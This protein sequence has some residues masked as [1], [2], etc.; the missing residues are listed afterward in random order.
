[1][2]NP[3]STQQGLGHF[4]DTVLDVVDGPAVSLGCWRFPFLRLSELLY[5]PVLPAP[6][7]SCLHILYHKF[8]TKLESHKKRH[9]P[10]DCCSITSLCLNTFEQVFPSYV[11][12]VEHPLFIF[13]CPNSARF[14]F[15]C[16]HNNLLQAWTDF[17]STSRHFRPECSS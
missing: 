11:L 2:T 9:R 12:T 6:T 1:M 13:L 16:S 3:Y 5:D 7:L 10:C 17:L 4:S 8:E 15:F 14:S